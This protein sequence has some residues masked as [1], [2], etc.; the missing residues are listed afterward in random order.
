MTTKVGVGKSNEK[1]SFKAGRDAAKLAFDQAGISACDFVFLFATVGYGQEELLKGVRSVTNDAP[2]SG[3]SGEGI[4]TQDGPE[5]EVMF[6]L[7]GSDKGSEIAGVLVFA[8]DEISFFNCVASGL[9]ENSFRAGQEIG[10]KI[11]AGIVKDPL[12]LLMFPDGFMVNSGQLF[13]GID[14]TLTTPLLYAGGLSGHNLRCSNITYQ[15]HNDTVLTDSITCVLISGKL[16]FEIGVNHGCLPIGIE[17]T[18]TKAKGN[19]VYEI[20]HKAAWSFFQEYLGEDAAQ[21]NSENSPTVSIGVKLHDALS[22]EYDKYIVRA[23]YF[24]NPD[25]SI[26]FATEMKEGTKVQ[27]VRRDEDKISQG[28][29]KLAERIKANLG[30]K[31]PIAVLHFDCAGRGKMFFGDKVK[32]KGI[33]VLQ[34]TLGK[35]IPWLGFYSF[36]EIAPINGINHHHNLTVALCVIYR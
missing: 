5:G 31:K 25:G 11:N 35:D 10:K 21:L 14:K 3:C 2:L 20:E 24:Q 4:I 32:S 8:S 19:A 26:L 33:D 1:D 22:K 36:G 13:S 18:I 15:Y 28:A 16:N 9:K 7:S 27:L 6:T 29:A 17:K 30:G 34:D 23:P 12:C